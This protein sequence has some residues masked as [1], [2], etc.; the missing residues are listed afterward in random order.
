MIGSIL[1]VTTLTW[2]MIHRCHQ[3]DLLFI[4]PTDFWAAFGLFPAAVMAFC[5]LP[6]V[7]EQWLC[8][9]DVDVCSDAAS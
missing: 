6:S 4:I 5:G 1:G 8:F 2:P 3:S 9:G 7:P